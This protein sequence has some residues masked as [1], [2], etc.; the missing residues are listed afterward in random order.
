ML[1]NCKKP[2][3]NIEQPSNMS[4]IRGKPSK[5]TLNYR[6]T[7]QNLQKSSKLSKICKK[8]FR[9]VEKP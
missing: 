8:T 9:N 6:K 3:K 5:V 7:T 4:K 2:L 1:K